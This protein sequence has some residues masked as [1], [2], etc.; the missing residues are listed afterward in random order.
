MNPIDAGKEAL[1]AIVLP[2]REEKQRLTERIAVIDQTLV[3]LEKA[4]SPLGSKA[5][6]K[7]KTKPN[8][9]ARTVTQEDVRQTLEKLLAGKRSASQE[10]LLATAKQKLKVEQG[11]DLKGFSN[12]CREV[13]AAEPFAVDA[14]GSVRLAAAPMTSSE[15]GEASLHQ[16][17]PQ[18]LGD[19]FGSGVLAR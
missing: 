4:I 11:L 16:G 18:S 2:L 10:S 13:L 8:T 6:R 9:T 15:P 12:R 19:K 14:A 5:R 3:P 17:E 7:K 1:E